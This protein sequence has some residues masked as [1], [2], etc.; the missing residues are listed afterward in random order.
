MGMEDQFSPFV[1]GMEDPVRTIW[2]GYG[3]PGWNHLLWVWETPFEP[4]AAI[5]VEVWTAVWRAVGIAVGIAVRV[6][7]GVAV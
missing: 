2:C 5:G 1:V 7:V 3:G 6:A 4:F